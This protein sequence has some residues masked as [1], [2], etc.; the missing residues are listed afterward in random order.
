M[1]DDCC[2][3]REEKCEPEQCCCNSQCKE[4]IKAVIYDYVDDDDGEPD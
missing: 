1:S 4:Q 3:D 2:K